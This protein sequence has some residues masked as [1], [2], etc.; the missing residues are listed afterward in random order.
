MKIV[1]AVTGGSGSIYA[2]DLIE[3]LILSEHL[4]DKIALIR[5]KNAEL[6]WKHEL[7]T[8]WPQHTKITYFSKNDFMAPFASGSAVYD[9]MIILPASMGTIGRIANGISDDL[10]SRAADVF[11]KE[12]KKLIICPREMPFNQIH[13]KNL[14]A[15]QQAGS[16][17]FPTS[18]SFY[19]KPS[20]IKKLI[21]TVTDRIIDHIGL[22]QK[23]SFRWGE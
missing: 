9:C 3:K 22:K 2:E 5:S 7:D 13:L 6:A 4:I 8:V 11:L 10:I 16:T 20:S 21:G 15:I 19:S 1:I 14:L 23:D 18:P 17:I 12:K